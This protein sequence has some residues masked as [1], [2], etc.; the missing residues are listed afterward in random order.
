MS[1]ADVFQ[2]HGFTGHHGLTPFQKRVVAL[3]LK[4]GGKPFL[5]GSLEA[6]IAKRL[7]ARGVLTRIK[8]VWLVNHREVSRDRHVCV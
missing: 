5:A 6:H 1:T 7:R 2:R 3:V 4:R 8:G